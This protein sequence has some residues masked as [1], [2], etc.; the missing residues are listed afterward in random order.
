MTTDDP[1][2]PRAALADTAVDAT[3]SA[4]TTTRTPRMSSTAL[5]GYVLSELIGRGGMGEVVAA[6]DQRL[7]REVAIKRMRD[8]HPD[9]ESIA[10]FVREAKIQARLDHPA[11]VPV[12]ELGS[13]EA[14]LPY[15]TMKRLV[16]VTLFDRMK[17]GGKI[18]PLLRAF[19]DVCFAVEL[20]HTRNI[21]HRDLKPSNIML[22]DYGDVYVLDWGVAR[23][24]GTELASSPLH[25]PLDSL[26]P[27]ETAAGAV[28]GTPGYMAPEQMRG[29]DV[30]PGADIYALGAILFEILAGESLHPPGNAAFAST[31]ADQSVSPA[32][33]R[34]DRE[35]AP[36][37]DRACIEALASDPAV[38]PTARALA[39][40]VQRY[41]DGDR[42]LEQRRHLVREHL[43]AAREALAAGDRGE[44]IYRGGRAL[45]L[46]AESA[47]AAEIVM[48]LTVKP[49]EVLPR[50]VEAELEGEE[51]KLDAQHARTG[52][53]SYLLI[54]LLVPCLPLLH[55]A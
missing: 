42:D 54:W 11:I 48:S 55:I 33:R 2:R 40:R 30:G 20:A 7:E 28:L 53:V 52:A 44:A 34:P 1:T 43:A 31:L 39:E 29:A 22:G 3:E 38:R 9:Q 13:D 41:L 46:D 26:P 27:S 15:F 21:V 25:L 16:G 17:E 50:E 23:V 6:H 8:A 10:R 51:I 35:I 5:G 32:E 19:I 18:Q 24:L 49:P 36:E 12:H 37:L 47:E 45:A 4:T 14:G